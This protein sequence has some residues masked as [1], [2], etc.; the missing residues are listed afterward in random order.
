MYCIYGQSRSDHGR[1][2]TGT[3]LRSEIR[4]RGA[5]DNRTLVRLISIDQAGQHLGLPAISLE[6][7]A[8]NRLVPHYEINGYL[9]FEPVELNRWVHLHKIEEL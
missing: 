9:L 2:F 4:T 5:H 1:G 7:A 6:L 8:R 3:I